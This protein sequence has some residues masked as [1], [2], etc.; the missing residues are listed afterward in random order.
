MVKYLRKLNGWGIEIWNINGVFVFFDNMEVLKVLLV[1]LE[2]ISGLVRVY[3]S[4]FYIF[5]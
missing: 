4:S 2:F 1:F 3:F 5:F